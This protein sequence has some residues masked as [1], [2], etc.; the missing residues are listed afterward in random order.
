MSIYLKVFATQFYTQNACMTAIINE[1]Y[2]DTIYE[3]F[4][5]KIKDNE[6]LETHNIKVDYDTLV[7]DFKVSMKAYNN[8]KALISLAL[9]E[10]AK[11][12]ENAVLEFETAQ[13]FWEEREIRQL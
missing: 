1:K 4:E 13:R 8:N 7:V 6:W 3:F 5:E 10:E 9:D 2:T 12:F 11:E